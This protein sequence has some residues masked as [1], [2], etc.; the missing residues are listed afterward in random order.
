M[1]VLLFFFFLL[2]A[3]ITDSCLASVF[4]LPS[5]FPRALGLEMEVK[6]R[7]CPSVSESPAGPKLQVT[8]VAHATQC[9][10][11]LENL[12]RGLCPWDAYMWLNLW[13]RCSVTAVPESAAAL[14]EPISWATSP[15]SQFHVSVLP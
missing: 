3:G 2:I 11:V 6:E 7:Q 13:Q 14:L 15:A 1:P 10:K 9:D 8:S 5:C 4:L 12:K